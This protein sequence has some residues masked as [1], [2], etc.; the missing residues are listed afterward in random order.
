MTI[1][2]ALDLS[3]VMTSNTSV[4]LLFSVPYFSSHESF[5]F[6]SPFPIHKQKANQGTRQ[7]IKNHLRCLA[8]WRISKGIRPANVSLDCP[9]GFGYYLYIYVS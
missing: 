2:H 5:L 6:K 9:K 1:D 4:T 8:R 7:R 3:S